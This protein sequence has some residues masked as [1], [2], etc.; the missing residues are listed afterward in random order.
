M[1]L[2]TWRHKGNRGVSG[3]YLHVTTTSWPLLWSLKGVIS[4]ERTASWN[5]NGPTP[6]TC[7][8]LRVHGL[9]GLHDSWQALTTGVTNIS[10]WRKKMGS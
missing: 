1:S 10:N 9:L 5:L 6:Q 4:N 2:Y 8:L 3:V 7:G